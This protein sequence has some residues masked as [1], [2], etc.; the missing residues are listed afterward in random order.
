MVTIKLIHSE[1]TYSIRH[2]VLRPNQTINDCKY[3]SDED[4]D[5]FH[6]GA[7]KDDQLISIGSFYLESHPE[8][9]GKDQYRLRGMAT[10]K[11]FRNLQAGSKL[12]AEG[13]KHTL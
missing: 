8:L 2:K 12:I 3:D 13:G 7:F 11:E 10:L 6:L 5:T 1:D 4:E 9:P